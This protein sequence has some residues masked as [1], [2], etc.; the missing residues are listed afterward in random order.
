MESIR[1]LLQQIHVVVTTTASLSKNEEEKNAWQTY[2]DHVNGMIDLALQSSHSD[3][4]CEALFASIQLARIEYSIDTPIFPLSPLQSVL[5]LIHS[6]P[7]Q[8][9]SQQL[10]ELL[11]LTI[12]Q[13]KSIFLLLGTHSSR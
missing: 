3:T 4:S 9:T 13:F 11:K 5:V 6:I 2:F 10:V 1:E 8:F 12:A 7:S